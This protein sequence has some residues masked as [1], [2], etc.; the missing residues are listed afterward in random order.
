MSRNPR[1][2]F[3]IPVRNDATRLQTCL[4][5]ILRNPQ[6]PGQIEIIVV[7]NGSTDDSAAVAV[8]LG[9]RV[10]HVEGGRV[11]ELRNYGAQHAR[12]NVLAFV[13]AD[14]EIAGGWLYAAL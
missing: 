13:D 4:R 8:R 11:A 5:S 14:N 9:A 1:V 10:L 3:V 2:S 6:A 12:G 7:D